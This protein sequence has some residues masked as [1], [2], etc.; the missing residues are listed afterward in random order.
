MSLWHFPVPLSRTGRDADVANEHLS[1]KA[2][3]ERPG[4]PCNRVVVYA[5]GLLA[6]N[7]G[8]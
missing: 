7:P 8:V 4:S 6:V 2:H 5:T 3:K 1:M